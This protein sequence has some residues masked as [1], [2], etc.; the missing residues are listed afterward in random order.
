LDEKTRLRK[1]VAA[2]RDAE[3]GREEKSA[4]IGRRLAALDAYA[5]ARVVAWFVGVK[6]EVV[7]RPMIAAALGGGRTVAVPWVDGGEIRL[8]RIDAL[9]E[10]APAPFGLLEP[11]VELKSDRSRSVPATAV[12]FFAVPGLAFDLRGGRLGHGRGYY[13]RLLGRARPDASRTAL[14]FECQLVETVPMTTTDLRVDRIV[15][16]AAVYE[17]WRR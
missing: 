15:T 5:A 13:D 14:A 8:C 17:G 16:E 12:D 3:S 11:P 6:S 10:L 1:E 9:S 4:A 2:R 7:T